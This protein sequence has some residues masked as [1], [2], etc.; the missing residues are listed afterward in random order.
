MLSNT[1]NILSCNSVSDS[2]IHGMVLKMGSHSFLELPSSDTTW[3]LGLV[4]AKKYLYQNRKKEPLTRENKLSLSSVRRIDVRTVP[5]P[6]FFSHTMYTV[7][8]LR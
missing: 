8:N 5:T 1:K 3:F 2:V 7:L 4:A 6:R